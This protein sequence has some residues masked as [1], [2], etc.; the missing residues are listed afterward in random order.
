M[1]GDKI[2]NININAGTFFKAILVLLLFI[3]IYILRDIAAVVLFSVV[4]AS[5][6]EP[7]ARWFQKYRIPRV[8]AVILVY[9]IAFSITGI[10]FYLVIPPIFS[11]LSNL[12]ASNPSYLQKPLALKTI[13]Q[14]L[15]ELPASISG[16]LLSFAQGAKEYV[17]E[18]SSGFFQATTAAFG[19]ALSFA[20]IIVLSFYL[21]VQ[22]KGIENFLRIVTPVSHEKYVVDLWFRSRDKIGG[23]LKGQILLGVLVGVLV[24]LGL[25]L[26]RI[27]YALTFAL[28]AAIFEL[29]PIFGPVLAS[30]PPIAVAFL[31]NPSTALAV[32]ALYVIIQQFENHLIYPLVIR[33][34]VGIPPIITILALIIGA[35]LGGFFGV[36]LSVPIMAVLFEFIAD[37][38]KKKKHIHF[39]GR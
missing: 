14:Y 16:L 11:E 20:L 37:I 13:Q 10:M 18:I 8:L 36:L 21:A 4:V 28:L 19:G 29:I 6:V 15:P 25:T 5:G 9:L 30:I 26:L 31:Q 12:S 39:D 1:N 38:E 34:T 23:W 24:F 32:I 2:I 27:P 17:G 3:F 35:K 22:E 33:K 7:A